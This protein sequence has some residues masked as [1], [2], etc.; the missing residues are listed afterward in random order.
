MEEFFPLRAGE[1]VPLTAFGAGLCWSELG[2]VSTAE[3]LAAVAEGPVAGS[4][5]VTRNQAGDGRAYYV[6]TTLSAEGLSELLP[7]ICADASVEP[8]VPGLPPNVEVIRRSRDGTDWTF[9]INHGLDDVR[10]PLAGVELIAGQELDG[11]LG[12]GLAA[13]AVAV[14]RSRTAP[15]TQRQ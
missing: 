2:R 10:L 14:V 11:G 13:G 3:V 5:A 9:C 6:A 8:L 4:P 12:L 7:V 15:T 1:S